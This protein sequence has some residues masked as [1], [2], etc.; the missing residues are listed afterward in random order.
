M[1]TRAA[2]SRVL[3]DFRRR[4]P[5]PAAGWGTHPSSRA[6]L[7]A[8]PSPHHTDE[9]ALGRGT[10]RQVTLELSPPGALQVVRETHSQTASGQLGG[11]GLRQTEAQGLWGPRGQACSSGR[12]SE[13]A[14]A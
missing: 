11:P 9:P 5:A 2:V 10:E 7:A 4:R 12:L 1:A 14:T 13:R 8:C 3:G 6:P